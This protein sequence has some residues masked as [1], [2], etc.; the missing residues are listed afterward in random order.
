[1]RE[2]AMRFSNIF[3]VAIS[4]FAA[5][6]AAQVPATPAVP[7]APAAKVEANSVAHPGERITVSV[8]ATA[9][10]VGSERFTLYDVA[11][12]EVHVFVEPDARGRMLR[13][14]WVQFEAYLP[15]MPHHHYD[16]SDNQR[17]ELGGVTTWMRSGPVRADAPMR[18][19]SDRE[20]V[21]GILKRAGIAIP[22][23]VMNVRMVQLLDDPQGTGK[24][25]RRELMV[26][27]SED[28]SLSGKTLAELTTDGMPNAGWEPI[29]AALVERATTST[30][31]ERQ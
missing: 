17:S 21:I 13:L 30:R 22:P 24:G 31:I 7:A 12:A 9:I 2:D 29:E 3:A 20:H 5:T 27:Y 11:D 23:E 16:Y 26:I 1:M 6:A 25:A 19:G 8:P 14:W 28:L 10:Y 4:S 15:S 18:A